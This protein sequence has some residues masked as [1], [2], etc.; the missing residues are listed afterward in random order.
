MLELLRREE[1]E[2]ADG[3]VDERKASET[4]KMTLSGIQPMQS[5]SRTSSLYLSPTDPSSPAL[6]PFCR[7][8][9]DLFRTAGFLLPDN[10]P[11]KL[12]ATIINTIY[13]REARSGKNRWSKDSGKIDATELIERYKD[14]EWVKDMKLDRVAIC[15]MGAKKIIEG[16]EVV[17]QIY[18]EVV[19]VP[20]P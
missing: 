20:L 10:R 6:T 3:P 19:S 14:Y 5:P 2:I 1:A 15:E 17:D 11:L 13:A 8:L 7:N 18:T 12:H 4:L 9:Q 16:G